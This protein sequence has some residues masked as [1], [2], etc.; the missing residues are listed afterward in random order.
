M[1]DWTQRQRIAAL[2]GQGI[3]NSSDV[4]DFE[5]AKARVL[6]LMLD[7]KWHTV[8]EIDAAAGTPGH[9]ARAG[10]RRYEDVRKGY[11]HERMRD[12]AG[13]R[14]FLYRI[15]GKKPDPGKLF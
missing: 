13:G 10:L 7:G 11:I 8:E 9:P 12:P 4:D 2:G 14:R 1:T 15:T 3:L 6:A 5:G